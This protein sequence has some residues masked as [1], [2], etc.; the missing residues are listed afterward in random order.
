MALPHRGECVVFRKRYG[1]SKLC[2]K[3]IAAWIARRGTYRKGV[4]ADRPYANM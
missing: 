4:I 3:S 2:A 1:A